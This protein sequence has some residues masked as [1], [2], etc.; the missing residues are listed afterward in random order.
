MPGTP[1]GVLNHEALRE[2]ATVM[3]TGGTNCEKFVAA[4][5]QQYGVF[6]DVPQEHVPVGHIIG[7]NTLRQVGTESIRL[8]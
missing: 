7:R 1:H 5:R 3:G 2:R 4:P 6:V 8:R